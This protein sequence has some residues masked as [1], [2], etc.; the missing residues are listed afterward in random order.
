MAM[1]LRVVDIHGEK[2]GWGYCLLR[3][4]I[5]YLC[6]LGIGFLTAVTASIFGWIFMAGLGKYK[7]FPQDSVTHSFVVRETKGVLVRTTPVSP[8][9][10]SP[11]TINPPRPS[12]LSDLDRLLEQGMISKEE[13]ERKKRE[14]EGK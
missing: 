10:T 7:R 13:W 12:P 11:S 4:L 5:L 1:G 9:I 6:G 8:G 14:M 3:A 2:P